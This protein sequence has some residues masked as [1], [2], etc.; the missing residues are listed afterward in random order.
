MELIEIF[1]VA[2]GLL[3]TDFCSIARNVRPV[4]CLMDGSV[5]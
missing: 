3:L 4:H 1:G 5:V 2:I